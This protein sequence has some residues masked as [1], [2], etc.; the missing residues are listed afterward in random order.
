MKK[1]FGILL[2]FT[3]LLT[4]PILSQ[5]FT[6][7]P[8]TGQ[9]TSYTT[10]FGEDSDYNR[11]PQSYT[12]LSSGGVDLPDTA[13]SS[14]GWVMVK[15]NVTGLI[16]EIKTVD[17][18]IHN[19]D[20]KYTWCDSNSATNEGDSGTCNGTDTETFINTLNNGSFGSF[21]D[22]RM[23]TIKELSTIVNYDSYNPAVDITFFSNTSGPNY[24]SYTT[25]KNNAGQAMTVHFGKGDVSTGENKS[26]TY[27]VRAVR[28]AQPELVAN[29]VD[30]GD[31]TV[32]DADTGLMWQQNKLILESHSW[33]SAFTYCK[34]LALAG[35]ND[36]RLPDI[37]ELKSLVDYSKMTPS[38]DTTFFPNT[39]WYDYWS[40]TTGADSTGDAWAV[41]SGFGSSRYRNKSKSKNIRAVRAG[42]SGSSGNSI[43]WYQDYDSDGYGNPNQDM[44]ASSQPSGYVFDN[45]DC[46][47]TDATIHPGAT[48]IAGDN[49]DQDCDGSDLAV[50]VDGTIKWKLGAGA[51]TSLAIGSN[52]TIYAGG[53]GLY[54]INPEGTGK[55]FFSTGGGGS[56]AS[57]AIGSDGTI[58]VGGSDNH[59]YAINPDGTEK[60]KFS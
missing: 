51:V 29:L 12:K 18:S 2:L 26:I 7:W 27:Y 23:P 40:S 35:Y 32:T 41:S 17:S 11:N 25:P 6:Q 13:T 57:P 9:T 37:N 38:I 55:W 33:D 21:T 10:T 43:I 36:W 58:Y 30:N 14:D 5:A 53:A 4:T 19:K 59:L 47:D 8:D 52:G 50:P 24:W 49:I 46:D 3:I 60:W 1:Y 34:A 16:W 28:G 31:G 48:E 20:N 15:D 39:S 44:S 54:A 45:N 42:Q 56:T 22:W